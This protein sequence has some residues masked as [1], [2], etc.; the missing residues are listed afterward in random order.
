MFK[1]T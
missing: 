1:S